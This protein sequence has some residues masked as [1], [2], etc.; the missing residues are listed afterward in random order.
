MAGVGRETTE[1]IITKWKEGNMK[2]IAKCRACGEPLHNMRT[3]QGHLVGARQCLN[4]D[5]KKYGKRVN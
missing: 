1:I 4:R 3:F 2:R 5:C